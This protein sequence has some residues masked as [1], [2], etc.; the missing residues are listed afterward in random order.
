MSLSESPRA[1]LSQLLA[2][3]QKSRSAEVRTR[4]AE[5]VGH[6]YANDPLDDRERVLACKICEICA[7]DLEVQV[8]AALAHQLCSSALLPHEL[9][10]RLA[11]D[12]Y[13]VAFPVLAYSEILSDAD[14]LS[15]I[16]T[17]NQAKLLAVSQRKAISATIGHELIERGDVQVVRSVVSN[18]NAILDE[19][20]LHRA[21]QRYSSDEGVR[22]ALVDRPLLPES[23]VSK[24]IVSITGGL[25]DRLVAHQNL[26]VHLVL[27]LAR[28]AEDTVLIGQRHPQIAK[29]VEALH[30]QGKLT[31]MLLLR[32][33]VKREQAF[34]TYGMAQLTDRP[35]Q[36]VETLLFSGEALE[37]SELYKRA[38]FPPKLSSAYNAALSAFRDTNSEKT[39]ID[40]IEFEKEVV[41]RL[42]Q[43][44]PYVSLANIDQVLSEI[45][46][47][48]LWKE[49][50]SGVDDTV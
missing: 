5:R 10:L 32:A 2:D 39:D 42:V 35:Q 4:V 29:L 36:M 50:T 22:I 28:R 47:S 18:P 23:V 49:Q 9:A 12:A 24:L 16:K 25:V 6:A 1:Q 30:G 48:I 34:F 13:E 27:D 11:K 14:L 33:L 46:R 38:G 44:Y 3:L 45:E 8:R 31:P 17:A 20:S 40:Q 19:A 41:L 43:A 15:I 21:L 7:V 37:R 26:P